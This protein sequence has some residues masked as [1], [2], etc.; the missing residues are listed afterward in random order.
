MSTTLNFSVPLLGPSGQPQGTVILSNVLS[1]ILALQPDGGEVGAKYYYWSLTLAN[2]SSITVSDEDKQL[3]LTLISNSEGL[4]VL[5]R[6][7]LLEII[8]Q[9]PQAQSESSSGA[10]SGPIDPVADTKA[11]PAVQQVS[12]I[13]NQAV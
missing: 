13:T 9:A 1:G 12:D 10:T 2:G 5:G 3:L 4:N 8:T 7:R 6:G 11:E